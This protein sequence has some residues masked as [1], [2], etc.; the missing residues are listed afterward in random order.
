VTV[1]NGNETDDVL[2]VPNWVPKPVL[3]LAHLMHKD[4]TKHPA[5]GEEHRAAAPLDM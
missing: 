4:V 3:H 2:K 5:D 1:R